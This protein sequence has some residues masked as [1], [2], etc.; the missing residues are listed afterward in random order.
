MSLVVSDTAALRD[1]QALASDVLAGYAFRLTWTI[2]VRWSPAC[3]HP[4]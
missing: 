3:A 1:S 4:D 2:I